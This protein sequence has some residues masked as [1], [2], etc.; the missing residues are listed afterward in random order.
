MEV[1]RSIRNIE[2]KALEPLAKFIG[3]ADFLAGGGGEIE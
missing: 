3:N 1:D 2:L